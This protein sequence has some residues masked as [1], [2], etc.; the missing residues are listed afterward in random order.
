MAP[1]HKQQGHQGDHLGLL[2]GIQK[3]CTGLGWLRREGLQ[4]HRRSP[5]LLNGACK[6]PHLTGNHPAAAPMHHEH[7]GRRRQPALDALGHFGIENKSA[8]PPQRGL[9]L[10]QACQKIHCF[11]CQDSILHLAL[12]AEESNKLGC[13]HA[14]SIPSQC[15]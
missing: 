12:M 6:S 5:A 7:Q 2:G 10:M 15:N 9:T 4:Q 13:C 1:R 14:G 11:G 3:T 8:Q